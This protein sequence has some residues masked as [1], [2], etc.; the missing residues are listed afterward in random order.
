MPEQT[1]E[2]I[3]KSRVN[4]MFA[5]KPELQNFSYFFRHASPEEQKQLMEDVARKANKDQRE[6][7]EQYE[8]SQKL[9]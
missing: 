6:L 1:K 4:K 7:V 2:F 8:Q 9:A 3:L 5:K